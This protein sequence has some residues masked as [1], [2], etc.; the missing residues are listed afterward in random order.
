MKMNCS[1]CYTLGLALVVSAFTSKV[2]AT[3]AIPGTTVVMVKG[4]TTSRISTT[5]VKPNRLIV[6][7]SNGGWYQQEIEMF[8]YGA[9]SS[10][11]EIKLPLRITSSSGNFQV[12][13]D[14]A[15]I[16]RHTQKPTLQFTTAVIS[17]AKE[18]SP[19]QTLAVGIPVQFHNTPAA[20]PL[21]D[22]IG[23]YSLSISALLPEGDLKTVA[24]IYQGDLKLTFEPVAKATE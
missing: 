1:I 19:Y 21:Q 7:D 12:S 6:N 17:M 15:L 4:K 11:Y 8:Q 16:L 20:Q 9:A 22:T 2:E 5:V 18:G 10:P 13:L 3:T 23:D 14:E 24:G